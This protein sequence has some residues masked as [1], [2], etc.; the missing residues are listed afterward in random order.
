MHAYP[1]RTLTPTD[2]AIAARVKSTSSPLRRCCRGFKER[3]PPVLGACRW[4]QP[5]AVLPCS[6]LPRAPPF[7]VRAAETAP[8]GD[9]R[10]AGKKM[11]S[12]TKQRTGACG[13]ERARR[14]RN[15]AEKMLGTQTLCPLLW[16]HMHGERASSQRALGLKSHFLSTFQKLGLSKGAQA[17]VE[18]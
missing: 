5:T 14:V 16:A 9:G 15:V 2:A 18:S 6:V 1:K 11:F 4:R 17:K 7:T 8:Y 12:Q 13:G 3:N 10:G